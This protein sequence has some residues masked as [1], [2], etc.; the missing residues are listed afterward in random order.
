MSSIDIL[1]MMSVD[2]QVM[3]GVW[4]L[5]FNDLG[6]VKRVTSTRVVEYDLIASV[7]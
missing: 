4:V 7:E 3:Q 2:V 5:S 6:V 1:E